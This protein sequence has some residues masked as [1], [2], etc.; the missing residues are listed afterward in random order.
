MVRA[1]RAER[2]GDANFH[3]MAIWTNM[4]NDKGDDPWSPER[5]KLL[6]HTFPYQVLENKQMIFEILQA[7]ENFLKA[8]RR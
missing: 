5:L 8:I 3:A 1:N 7:P 4:A 2:C 6:G